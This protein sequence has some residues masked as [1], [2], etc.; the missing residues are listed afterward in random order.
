MYVWKCKNI[1]MM[2]V[3][4]VVVKEKTG[5]VLIAGE[6]YNPG[7]IEYQKGKHVKMLETSYIYYLKP[8][9]PIKFNWGNNCFNFF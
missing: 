4:S 1:V 7:L 2:P 6:V 9:I 3:D 5:T 8:N